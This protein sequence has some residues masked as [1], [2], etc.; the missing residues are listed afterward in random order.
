M[1]CPHLSAASG[2]CLLQ[3][4]QDPETEDGREPVVTDPVDRELCLGFG[5]HR[6]DCPIFRRFL[7][8]LVP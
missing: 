3:Q 8:E 4:D 1:P 6:R 7:A 2:D 5:D